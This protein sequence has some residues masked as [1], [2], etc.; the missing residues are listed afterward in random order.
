LGE[1]VRQFFGIDSLRRLQHM[2]A[3]REIE[4]PRIA[5]FAP[6]V[7]EAARAGDRSAVEVRREAVE[8][9]AELVHVAH[10]RL[11]SSLRLP[12]API[13]GLFAD[14]DFVERWRW[15][16]RA[17][18]P[19]AQIVKPKHGPAVGALRIAYRDAGIDVGSLAVNEG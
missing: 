12:I 17:L 13:G 7:L 4:R 5:A 11:G 15:A 8:A 6:N 3:H 1:R 10:R 16:M 19:S 2:V 9:L 18:E 14:G